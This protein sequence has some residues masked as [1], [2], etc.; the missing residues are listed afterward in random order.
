MAKWCAEQPQLLTFTGTCWIHR[1]EVLALHGS[2][3]EALD[4][5]DRV[6]ERCQTRPDPA[7]QAAACYQRGEIHRLRGDLERAEEAY[8]CASQ[9]GYEPQPGLAL[10]RLAQGRSDVAASSIRRLLESTNEPLGRARL[11]PAHIEISLAL[12]DT[13]EA[14]LACEELE[15]ISKSYDT[16]VLDAI[17]SQS[18]GAVALAENEMASAL[19]S[20]RAALA[21]WNEIQVPYW[22]ARTRQ[23]IG[24]VCRALGDED[25]A[26]LELEA[27]DTTLRALGAIDARPH[28]ASGL[29]ER[30][31]QVLRLVATGKTNK[32]IAKEL[33]LSEKTIDRHL[34]NIFVKLNVPS[35]AAATAYAYER[36]L[37]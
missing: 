1:A 5:V 34:S 28:T 17:A 27:A 3:S 23:S 24:L 7:T 10:L 13:S 26:T 25:G 35:R 22:A 33:C 16:P 32:A 36:K 21:I 4:E 8:R 14:K 6:I 2:W 20:L 37:I 11:L 12:G 15:R 18:R 31:L 9:G 29:T 19:A 30:E